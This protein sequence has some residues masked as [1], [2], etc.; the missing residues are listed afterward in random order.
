MKNK[1]NISI[2]IIVAIFIVL[3]VVTKLFKITELPLQTVGVLFGA[4]ITALITYF[5]LLGQS[6][7][8]EI[9]ERNVKVFEEKNIRYNN[10]INKLWEIWEDRKV[11][12][13]EL[14]D[15][16]KYVSKDIIL[17]TKPETVNKILDS[18]VK[19]AE[20]INVNEIKL[21]PDEVSK[22]IQENVF[23]IINELAK[24][25][26]L[27]GSIDADI[28]KKLNL[29]EQKVVPYLNK[30][31]VK[32][33]LLIALEEKLFESEIP[34]SKIEYSKEIFWCQINNSP[35]F[36]RISSFEREKS[37]NL[38]IGF[39]VDYY[40]YPNFKKYRDAERG[41]R[42]D[43]L[44]GNNYDYNKEFPNFNDY[45]LIDNLYNKIDVLKEDI[46]L[47]KMVEIILSYYNKWKIDNKNLLEIIEECSNHASNN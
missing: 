47:T 2:A 9:K 38:T 37:Q 17:F 31:I 44:K 24:E 28:R 42:K 10:F 36:L 16:I 20:L 5:L 11:T 29:L 13:E 8:E 41:W 45:E 12:L 23:H 25:I 6:Q 15:L 14:N 27:G 32:E 39:F 18:L 33:K 30:K 34:I 7:A 40:K 46:F 26:G 1:I 22:T 35:V 43:F 3:I 4:V 21:K 19:I